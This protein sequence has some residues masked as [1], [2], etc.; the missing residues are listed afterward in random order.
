MK[1][2]PSEFIT[3]PRSRELARRQFLDDIGTHGE[4][5]F[6]DLQKDVGIASDI[7][8]QAHACTALST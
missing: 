1:S 5:A 3:V 2:K 4:T 6:S 8:D 7:F